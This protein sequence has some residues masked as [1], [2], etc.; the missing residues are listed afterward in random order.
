M[1]KLTL[2]AYIFSCERLIFT[3]KNPE[4]SRF[5][6][7]YRFADF[8]GDENFAIKE[9]LTS[10][11]TAN[12]HEQESP[13]FTNHLISPHWRLLKARCLSKRQKFLYFSCYW[14]NCDAT[15]FFDLSKL[16]KLNVMAELGVSLFRHLQISLKSPKVP[17]SRLSFK[18]VTYLI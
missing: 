2:S 15:F 12:D 17:V 14:S 4:V 10:V 3:P 1:R 5:N 18:Y 9:N 7:E 16:S 6:C 11:C 8:S 13:P